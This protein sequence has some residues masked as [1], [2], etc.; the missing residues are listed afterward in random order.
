MRL[1]MRERCTLSDASRVK[2]PSPAEG[3][4][5]QMQSAAIAFDNQTRPVGVT[6]SRLVFLDGEA[7]SVSEDGCLLPF[8]A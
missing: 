6:N 8:N 1:K 7:W 5:G 2:R 3:T 4:P